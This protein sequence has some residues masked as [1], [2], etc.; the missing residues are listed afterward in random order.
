M[1]NKLGEIII[2]IGS[3]TLDGSFKDGSSTDITSNL[4]E[5]TINKIK[6]LKIGK[7]YFLIANITDNDSESLD[8]NLLSLY[9]SNDNLLYGISNIDSLGDGT[10]TTLVLEYTTSKVYLTSL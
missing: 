7:H 9:I 5:E 2:N 8:C 10:L 1:R 6:N 3:I 4:D